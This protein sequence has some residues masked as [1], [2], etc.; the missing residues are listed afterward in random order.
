VRDNILI[1]SNRDD[2]GVDAV[3]REL[4]DLGESVFRFDFADLPGAVL[5]A[6]LVTDGSAAR[7]NV[8]L[9]TRFRSLHLDE[10]KSV[11]LRHPS[12]APVA[13]DLPWQVVRFVQQ[14]VQHTFAG[15]LA[16]HEC[17]FVNDP[18]RDSV[19]HLKPYQLAEA[20]RVGLRVPRSIITTDPGRL[21][22][23]HEACGGIVCKA[24]TG[25]PATTTSGETAERSIPTSRVTVADL[26]HAAAV[27]HGPGFFQELIASPFQVR[28]TA[29]GG[30]LFAVRIDSEEQGS[31]AA[32]DWRSHGDLTYTPYRLATDVEGM[33]R[34]LIERFGLEFAGIDLVATGEEPLADLCFLELNPRGQWG[35]LEA[36]TGLPI[37]AAIAKLLASG[38]PTWRA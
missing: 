17:L 23:F 12:H 24:L 28:V 6:E 31:T 15:L 10:V 4:T 16:S 36:A 35:W 3:V 1:L 25:V 7:W 21:R 22:A 34:V 18:V 19:A 30:E 38:V 9:S 2:F 11:W 5:G 27:R 20:A 14:E 33:L 29:V 13:P 37:S 26:D 8:A 32:A